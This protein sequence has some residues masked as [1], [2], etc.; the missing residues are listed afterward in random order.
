MGNEEIA[1][2]LAELAKVL[3]AG[4]EKLPAG[5]MR[6][7]CEKKSKGG[8]S[9]SKG[10]KKKDSKGGKDKMPAEVLE[11][12]KKKSSVEV[13]AA[14]SLLALARELV[15]E[16]GKVPEEFKE[17]WKNKDKDGDGKE[18]EPKPDFLK[19]SSRRAARMRYK[20]FEGYDHFND[21]PLYQVIGVNND[22]VGEW[23]TE[24]RDAKKEL[25]DLSRQRSSSR[26]RRAEKIYDNGFD[27]VA[28]SEVF[29]YLDDLRE[30]GRT[31]MFGA[32]RYIESELGLDRRE[33]KKAL[34][35]WMKAFK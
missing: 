3:T 30:S 27:G 13:R 15:A 29:E 10:E 34:M 7:N 33:A 6:D 5:P 22:Y 8:D 26:R 31:N 9:G 14:R 23:H 35:A 18:N 11:K 16:K 32:A 12:F 17:E 2:A 24:E 1:A 28:E 25:R 21:S 20:V 4:C 19:K